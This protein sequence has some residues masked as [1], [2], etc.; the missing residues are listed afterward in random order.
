M[1]KTPSLLIRTL[2]SAAGVNPD[3][4]SIGSVEKSITSAISPEEK[5]A[6]AFGIQATGIEGE[7]CKDIADRQRRGIAKYGITVLEN[8]LHFR[9]WLQHLYEELLDAAIYIKRAI[10]E[11]DSKADDLK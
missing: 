4:P 10:S 8:P 6:A 5:L 7:V 3:D 9:A 11:I 2:A 1:K